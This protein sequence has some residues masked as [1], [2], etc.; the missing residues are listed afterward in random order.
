MERLNR[1]DQKTMNRISQ[2]YMAVSVAKCEICQ[3]TV[4]PGMYAFDI[5]LRSGRRGIAHSLCEIEYKKTEME[6]EK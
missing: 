2:D 3:R 4:L 1:G 5:G 6:D